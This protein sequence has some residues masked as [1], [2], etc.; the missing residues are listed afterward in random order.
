MKMK[1]EILEQPTDDLAW[2][3]FLAAQ[4][5]GHHVQSSPWGQLKAKYAWQVVRIIATECG[6]IVGGAQ[7]LMRRLPVWGRVGYITRGPVVASGRHDVMEA[8]FDRIEQVARAKRLLILSIEPP[9]H[10]SLYMQPLNVRQFRPSSFY[11]IP[12]TTVVV[13]LRQSEDEVLAQFKRGTR[14]NVGLALRK[15]IVV[16]EGNETDLPKL[17]EWMKDTAAENPYYFYDLAYYQEAWRLFAPR[18]MLKL[19]MACFEDEPISGIIVLALGHWAVYKWGASSGAH[20]AKKPNDLLQW[21]GIRWSRDKGCHYYDL[22]GITPSVAEALQR[23]EEP[24]EGK[25]TGIARFKLGFGQMVSFP[26]S[27][28][29]SYGI[30]PRWLVRKGVD[31]GWKLKFLRNVARGARL[32]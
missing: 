6:H 18:G 24:P 3:E 26:S 32:T 7:V 5:A 1:I 22:G 19:L 13:D 8:L 28:D 30:R 17:F 29:N 23:G 21:H 11:V 14:Y 9:A 27:Y 12:P 25:G 2:D 20:L 16:R 31:Y 15:G 4:P 10:E